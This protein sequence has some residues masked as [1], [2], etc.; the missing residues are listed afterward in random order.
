M[1]LGQILYPSAVTVMG[2]FFAASEALDKA[3]LP[4]EAYRIRN[5]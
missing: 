5:V 2:D 3:G 1:R 4:M